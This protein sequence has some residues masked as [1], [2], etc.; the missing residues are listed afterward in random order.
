MPH[1]VVENIVPN[2]FWI[3]PTHIKI[4]DK[5]EN[6]IPSLSWI[7]ALTFSIVS[8]GSTSRVMVLPVKVF[9]KICIVNWSNQHTANKTKIQFTD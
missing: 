5:N 7:L 2:G 3:I 8:D 6:S 9:T 4:Y 1:P